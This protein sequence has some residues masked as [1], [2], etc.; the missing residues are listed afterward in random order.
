[1]LAAFVVLG[2]CVVLAWTAGAL[3]SPQAGPGRQG[4]PKAA[5]L[6][7]PAFLKTYTVPSGQ[8]E[9][10]ANFLQSLTMKTPGVKILAVNSSTLAVY[11]GPEE[12]LAIA[13]HLQGFS[14]PPPVIAFIPLTVVDAEQIA[15]ILRMGPDAPFI[16]ADRTRKG[17]IVR[18]TAQQLQEV[19]DALRALGE[20][21][22]PRAA[23][24]GGS[25][26][27]IPLE[28]GN[29][30]TVAE[31]VKEMLARMRSNPV[32]VVVPE[33]KAPG[34]EGAK[35][36]A[37]GTAPVTLTAAGNKLIVTSDD[38]QVLALVEE[39]VR[40][41]TQPHPNRDFEVIRLRYARAADVAQL[42]DEAF[43]GR[44]RPA[45]PGGKAPAADER[46]RVVAEP[47]TNAV[48]VRASPLDM[49]TIRRLVEKAL[50]LASAGETAPAERAYVIGPLRHARAADMVKIL[51]AVY[52]PTLP[53]GA[54]FSI[55]VDEQT[56]VLVL[57]CSEA[58]YQEVRRLVRELEE[59]PRGKK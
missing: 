1:L 53:A 47:A 5:P 3:A 55:A 45:L 19:R 13:R 43:N 57:H 52:G 22:S 9:T 4:P 42:L 25:M 33:Q 23:T 54:R 40:L 41:L 28:K 21:D 7:G 2:A 17:V 36:S 37:K 26:K 10:L 24:A 39:L 14:S 8:A 31:A 15:K 18:G 38:K 29:A 6:A 11:A 56:N 34:K 20:P 30:A 49:L 58:L 59:L 46:I 50:D 12:Q 35:P 44:R 51:M 32:R 16:E 48:L 27:V